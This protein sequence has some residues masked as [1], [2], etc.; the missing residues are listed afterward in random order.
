MRFSVGKIY[1]DFIRTRINLQCD[2]AFVGVL[3]LGQ[4][5]IVSFGDRKLKIGDLNDGEAGATGDFPDESA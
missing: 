1:Y 4:G 3:L 5:V 2:A